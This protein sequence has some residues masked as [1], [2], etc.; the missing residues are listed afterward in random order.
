MGRVKELYR[1]IVFGN[2]L[3]LFKE[4]PVLLVERAAQ[5]CARHL[6]GEYAYEERKREKYRKG[7][8]VLPDDMF[9][10]CR[11]ADVAVDLRAELRRSEYFTF[12]VGA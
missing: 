10:R 4:L 1:D 7:N 8:T 3:D 2:V 6:F 12:R 9:G 11:N 5:S